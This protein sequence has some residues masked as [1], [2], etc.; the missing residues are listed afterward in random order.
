VEHNVALG[1]PERLLIGLHLFAKVALQ[2]SGYINANQAFEV[3]VSNL[4]LASS[5][6]AKAALLRGVI[7]FDEAI[8]YVLQ[9][10]RGL[11]DRIIRDGTHN[12]HSRPQYITKQHK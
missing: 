4:V 12:H 3:V 1:A 10:L 6:H 9:L 8:G 2:G 7:L 5:R 11:L